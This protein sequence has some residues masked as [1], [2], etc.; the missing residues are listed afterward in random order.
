[1]NEQRFHYLIER[2]R[3]DTLDHAEYL[4]LI[5]MLGESDIE[6]KLD[7]YLTH[8]WEA[9]KPFSEIDVLRKVNSKAG[10]RW[11]R[12]R[13][14]SVAASLILFMGLFYFL[15]GTQSFLG[16]QEKIYKT[17]FGER[18]EIKLNDGSRITLNANSTLKWAGGWEEAGTR[19][20]TLKGE[21][22][23][24]VKKLN[25]ITFTVHT[26]DVAVEVL[27]TVFNINSW[28]DITKVYLETGKINLKLNDKEHNNSKEKPLQE[29][30]MK[31]GDQVYY[32][33]GEK[34][35]KKFNGQTM[36]TAAAWKMNVLNFKNKQFSEVLNLLSDIYGQSFECTDSKLLGTPMYLGVP[37]S[38]W[39][40]VRQ[41]LEL[42][43]KIQ[44]QKIGSQQ[45]LVKKVK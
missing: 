9:E 23:F 20:A 32:S 44:F 41:A 7:Q 37:Y 8:S 17:G 12:Y 14:F 25:G 33:A 38:N 42:S 34:K 2:Y 3:K 16:R 15:W 13:Y 40:T 28:G 43:M 22:F 26:N 1:M 27:G 36:I 31:S 4:E 18:L 6:G 24:E 39:D 19:E 45:Y 30:T 5:W 10:K 35:I 21:A 29:V 11:K